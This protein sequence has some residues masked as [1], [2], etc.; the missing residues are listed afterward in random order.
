MFRTNH[1]F[2]QKALALNDI[3]L[4][5]GSA[6]QKRGNLQL[7]D[8]TLEP[9]SRKQARAIARPLQFWPVACRVNGNTL[10]EDRPHLNSRVRVV[11]DGTF[12]I[13]QGWNNPGAHIELAGRLQGILRASGFPFER[14]R[15][16]SRDTSSHRCGTARFGLDPPHAPLDPFG[17]TFD[18]GNLFVED[19]TRFPSSAAVIPALTI[20]AKALRAGE[21][22]ASTLLNLRC[23]VTDTLISSLV[24]RPVAL[25]SGGRRGIG[26]SIAVESAVIGCDVAYTDILPGAPDGPA[27]NGIESAGGRAIYLCSDLSDLDGHGPL[28]DAVVDWGGAQD[29]RVNNAG[30][31]LPRQSDVLSIT[32]ENCDRV[33]G[34][35]LRGTLFLRHRAAKWMVED[36]R[37]DGFLRS[38]VT[39]SSVSAEMATPERSVY[40]LSQAGLAMAA[41]LLAL[42]RGDEGVSVYEV[43]PG[44]IRTGMTAERARRQEKRIAGGL[45]PI[46]RWGEPMDVARATVAPACSSFAFATGSILRADGGLSIQRL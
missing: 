13:E 46:W 34:V 8:K 33:L 10:S 19:A 23:L 31:G 24:Q 16:F 5:D 27:R 20:A 41:E 14:P 12:I 6:G 30:I 25:V 32:P 45:S 7:L 44:I 17:K 3:H 36:P 26:A 35:N 37:D 1:A 18:C 11:G 4:D 2:S 29:K 40:C 43:R 28:V 21:W 15:V 42:R 38:I 9:F 39:V 22:L